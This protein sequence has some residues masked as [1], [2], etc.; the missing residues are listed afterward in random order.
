M[1]RCDAEGVMGVGVGVGTGGR[2]AS[3]VGTGVRSW[4]TVLINVVPLLV[5]SRRTYTRK[6]RIQRSRKNSMKHAESRQKSEQRLQHQYVRNCHGVME[7]VSTNIQIHAS[8]TIGLVET[9]LKSSQTLR[10]TSSTD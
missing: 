4:H 6:G 7:I 5:D 3:G 9:L 1:L 2:V 8:R 10:T